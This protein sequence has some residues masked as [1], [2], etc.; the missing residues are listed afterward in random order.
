MSRTGKIARLP[1]NLRHQLNRRLDD[2]LPHADILAW[3]N[4]LPETKTLL[5]AEFEGRPVSP[6]NLT[7]WINGGYHDWQIQQNALDLAG[8]LHE[9][10]NADPALVDPAFS[11][12][13]SQ[14][15]TLYYA[16]ILRQLRLESDRKL[17]WDRL[18]QLCADVARLRR[19]EL[20]A[21]RLTL[22]R[23]RLAFDQANSQAQKEKEFWLWTEREDI[24]KKLFPNEELGLSEETLIKIEKELGLL[25]RDDGVPK[26]IIPAR[27]RLMEKKAA[28]AAAKLSLEPPAEPT[29]APP[30]DSSAPLPPEPPEKLT[31][32]GW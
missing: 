6:A 25:D 8:A 23:A 7:G 15:L 17:R 20:S 1:L 5:A 10:K 28:E 11:A 12:K 22:D 3:L 4:D 32:F 27:Q 9:A 26:H 18:R 21:E 29:P 13:L 30:D 16:A 2:G 14:W 19:G 24:R 31:G